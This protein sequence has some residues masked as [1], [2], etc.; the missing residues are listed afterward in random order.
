MPW[1]TL[2]LAFALALALQPTPAGAQSALAWGSA[3][4]LEQ[5]RAGTLRWRGGAPPYVVRVAEWDAGTGG[6]TLAPVRRVLAQTDA[7]VYDWDPVDY[8]RGTR[9]HVEVVDRAGHVARP[10]GALTV[11]DGPASCALWSPPTFYIGDRPGPG[12]HPS[13]DAAVPTST[14]AAAAAATTSRRPYDGGPMSR[15]PQTGDPIARPAPPEDEE[16]GGGGGGPSAGLVAGTAVAGAAVLAL[17]AALLLWVR[18]LRHRVAALRA[19]VAAL[20]IENDGAAPA[21]KCMCMY[22]GSVASRS[23]DAV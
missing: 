17:V 6:V 12:L 7:G 23:S 10:A 14:A 20:E 16:D 13:A 3:S 8:A 22:E 1:P 18:R 15:E 5:C 19:R 21:H 11:G 2:A 9:L 4:P